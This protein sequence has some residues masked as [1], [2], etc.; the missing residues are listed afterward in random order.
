MYGREGENPSCGVRFGGPFDQ[1]FESGE[2][3]DRVGARGTEWV[4]ALA[5]IRDS[6][7]RFCAGICTTSRAY[8]ESNSRDGLNKV[9]FFEA[10]ADHFKYFPS[11]EQVVTPWNAR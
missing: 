7:G 1:S 9:C 5:T 2:L 6:R 11:D 3:E 8:L 4:P 10:M